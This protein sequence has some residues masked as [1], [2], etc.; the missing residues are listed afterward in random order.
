MLEITPLLTTRALDE[1]VRAIAG[2]QSPEGAIAEFPGGVVSPWNHIEAAMALDVGGLHD[3]ALRAYEWLAS[4]QRQD[5]AWPAAYLGLEVVDR[6][7]DANFCSYVAFGA[8]HH[9]VFTGDESFLEHVWPMVDRAIAFTIDLQRE[10]GAIRWAR[11]ARGKAAR[12]ALL[13][14]CACAYMSL[15]SALHIAERTGHQ[16]P[17]WELAREKLGEA[18]RTGDHLFEAKR[19]FSMDWYYPVLARAL[20]G[21]AAVDRLRSR[22]DEFVVEGLGV[23][24]VSDKPWVTSGETAE[25]VLALH[26]AG[27]PLEAQRLLEWV[28]HLRDADGAYWIGAT[29]PDGTV[30]PRQ[31][32]TWGTGSVVL[33]ADVLAG[34]RSAECF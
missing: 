13:T 8:W 19:R 5:G 34:G 21:D 22:W 3:G 16:R 20:T 1:T 9:F 14:S 30:W 4:T 27:L 26:V 11:D 12:G 10:D 18:I 2:V 25:L 17:E 23:R 31:K 7:L 6:T 24:C 33:A 29:F 28:Q 15:R 32:P